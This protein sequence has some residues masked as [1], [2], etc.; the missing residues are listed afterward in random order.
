MATN[1]TTFFKIPNTITVR[2]SEITLPDQFDGG[3]NESGSVNVGVGIATEVINPKEQDWTVLDQNGDGRTPQ[4]SQYIGGA[5]LESTKGDDVHPLRFTD[6]TAVSMGTADQQAD[7]GEV[8]DTVNEITSDSADT[9]EIGDKAFGS[10]AYPPYPKPANMLAVAGSQ[11]PNEVIYDT[12]DADPANWTYSQPA[13]PTAGV[14]AELNAGGTY[15]ACGGNGVV[16]ETVG[17]TAVS[18]GAAPNISTIT[19]AAWSFRGNFLVFTGIQAPY[20]AIYDAT[21]FEK[22]AN[23]AVPPVVQCNGAGFSPDGSICA[24][25]VTQAPFIILYE[26]AG[27]TQLAAPTYD[28]SFAC[29]DAEFSPD[30]SILCL[31]CSGTPYMQ[32]YDTSDWSQ[33]TLPTTL[34]NNNGKACAWSADGA[35]LAIGAESTSPIRVYDTSDWSNIALSGMIA[36]NGHTVSFSPDN[37]FL[38]CAGSVGGGWNMYN[39]GTWT[40]ANL[41]SYIL[42]E[43]NYGSSFG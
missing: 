40:A 39:Q 26:T 30:G 7:T 20:L 15:L 18:L 6:D 13:S 9:I 32:L 31:A 12:T 27:W 38:F 25:A 36:Y 19:G 21:T 41:P 43:A 16:Y 42:P 11:S 4:N 17:L 5:G 28:P 14:I 10:S 33:I 29:N 24:V 37:L 35:F 1:K 22:L 23:P 2:K 8:F 34:P 3:V